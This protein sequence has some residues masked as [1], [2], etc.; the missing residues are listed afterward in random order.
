MLARVLVLLIWLAAL[1]SPPVFPQSRPPGLATAT[2][3]ACCFWCAEEAMD[4]VPG[5]ISTTS[6][7]MGGSAKSP[8][9]EAV[10]SGATGHT[11]VVQVVYDPK[12][13]SYE[14]LLEQ[15][16][17]NHDPTVK[18][19]QF[20][21]AGSQYRPSIFWHDEEQKRLAEASK[22]KWERGKP[23]KQAIVTPIVK[24]T[25]FWPAED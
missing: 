24:A 21:D 8:T 19:R 16:W 25:E 12:K 9:Y 20:C 1:A 13:V 23:F 4:K 14:R 3:A 18:D 15:F 11:E 7:F 22:V 10:S 17:L 6:G 2:F 5:V